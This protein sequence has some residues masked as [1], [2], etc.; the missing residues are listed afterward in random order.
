MKT[1][2]ISF[3]RS[4]GKWWAGH[5]DTSAHTPKLASG[6]NENDGKNEWQHSN[7]AIV[8]KLQWLSVSF[9]WHMRVHPAI[10]NASRYLTW[11]F[12]VRRIHLVSF[13]L[14]SHR[15]VSNSPYSFQLFL[16]FSMLSPHTHTHTVTPA[17][18]VE[19]SKAPDCNFVPPGESEW[20]CV[21]RILAQKKKKTNDENVMERRGDEK[22]NGC[23]RRT[24]RARFLYLI[25]CTQ[26]I[27]WTKNVKAPTQPSSHF[28]YDEK[29][30]RKRAKFLSFSA[31]VAE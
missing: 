12:S 28:N 29:N 31:P 1:W 22:K 25:S 4:R 27:V 24:H 16:S 5:C 19:W 18:L 21:R 3:A 23:Q 17:V 10:V 30:E 6:R 20:K 15:V 11:R 2:I 8:C 9:L 7:T 13:H 14:V 26:W